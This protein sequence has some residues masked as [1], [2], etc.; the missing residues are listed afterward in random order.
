MLNPE[1][2]CG[3]DRVKESPVSAKAD[4]SLDLIRS[5]IKEITELNTGGQTRHR[6]RQIYRKLGITMDP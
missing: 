5:Q 3:G 6:D 4:T 2:V 1:A